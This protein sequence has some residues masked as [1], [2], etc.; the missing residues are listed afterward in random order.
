MIARSATAIRKERQLQYVR[1]QVPDA[2]LLHK[3]DAAMNLLRSLGNF[4]TILFM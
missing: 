4:K 3:R 2:G 1:T